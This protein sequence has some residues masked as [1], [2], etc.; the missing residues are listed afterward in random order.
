[1]ADWLSYA[2][3]DFLMFGPEVYRRLFAL[4]NR[5]LWPLPP[6]AVAVGAAVL[7]LAAVPGRRARGVVGLAAALGW[8]GAAHFLA[9]RYVPINWAL[10]PA[11]WAFAAQAGALAACAVAGG[12]PAGR[13]GPAASRRIGLGLLG[14]AVLLHP[15]IGLAFDRPPLQA[16]IAGLAP[17]PTA[18][19]TLG[20]LLL[21]GR[22]A[23]TAALSLVPLAWCVVSAAT[24]FTLGEPQGWIL[25]VA[26]ALWVAG[27]L[28]PAGAERRRG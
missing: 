22:G 14:Y 15:L 1:M 17:D 11:A 21:R 4:Q 26:L 5:A 20:I 8:A 27:R 6:V 2:P 28:S 19:A 16:E 25:V 3:D 12:R 24:L 9:A 10:E 23:R 18:L 7:A 13:P